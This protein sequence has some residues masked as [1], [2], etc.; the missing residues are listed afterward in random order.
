MNRRH[1]LRTALLL[2]AALAAA[3]PAN[4]ADVSGT[5]K[6]TVKEL[7]GD[8]GHATIER[9]A[10][11]D[12]QVTGVAVSEDNRI[13]VNFPRWSEDAPM[14]VGEWKDGRLVAYPNEEWNTYRNA[15]PLSPG[16]HSSACRR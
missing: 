3:S 13:F 15:A 8:T 1:T 11:F 2:S 12:H 14:S 5:V 4:A 10:T 6:A 7:A 16:D 9:V